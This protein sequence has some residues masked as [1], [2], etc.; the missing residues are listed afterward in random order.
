MGKFIVLLCFALL[1][2]TLVMACSPPG[3]LCA[4]DDECCGAFVCNP[5]ANR[6][7]GGPGMGPD[8]PWGIEGPRGAGA[9]WGGAQ[10]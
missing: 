9:P 5:W 7:T 2:M 3:M 10:Q 8:G 4:S 1:A 6:C